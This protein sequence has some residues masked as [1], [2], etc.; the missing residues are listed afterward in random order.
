MGLIASLE[1]NNGSIIPV[2]E[3]DIVVFVGA[4]NAGKSQCLRDIYELIYDPQNPATVIKR[5]VL[6][7]PTSQEAAEIMR[8]NCQTVDPRGS[9]QTYK[10]YGFYWQGDPEHLQVRPDGLRTVRD[11]FVSFQP[12]EKRLTLATPPRAITR[13]SPKEHPIHY[14]SYDPIYRQKLDEYF[15]KAFDE[16]IVPNTQH[17]ENI[18]LCIGDPVELENDYIDEQSRLEA[19][20]A[21]LETYPMAHVQGDGIRS[22]LGLTLELMIERYRLFLLD[23]PEAFLHPPQA[24]IMGEVIANITEQSGQVFIATHSKDL[25]KGLIKT[26]SERVRVIRIERKDGISSFWPIEN[27]TLATIWGDPILRHSDILDCLFYKKTVI[28][29]SDSDC[30]MYSAILSKT[31]PSA[32]RNIKFVYSGGKQRLKDLAV[33]LRAL[34]IPFLV[35]PDLDILNDK[36]TFKTLVEG[37]GGKWDRIDDDYKI[38]SSQIRESGKRRVER[39][40]IIELINSRDD[41]YISAEESKQIRE[42]VTQISP[43]NKIKQTGEQ[44]IPR[45]SATQAYENIKNYCENELNI[46][47]VPCGEIE[48]FIKT[49]GGHGSA[50]VN[51]ALSQYPDLHDPHYN[52]ISAFVRKWNLNS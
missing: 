30:M 23:E 32:Y 11:L 2:G 25:I 17:G 26:A 40:N 22:F 37:C 36:N 39:I 9:Y 29:E 6:Q 47:L 14:V 27:N 31:N 45:G 13:T 50:W 52:E 42:A 51:A 24:K 12:T 38:L 35:V 3:N 19:Y 33:L 28:C 7:V 15:L 34:S 16:H 18:P 48:G 20:A 41:K 8:A 5:V 46:Y 1:M 10:T 4:N 43:W 44:A 49:C 21:I